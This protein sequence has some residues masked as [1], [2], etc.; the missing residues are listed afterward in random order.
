MSTT[1][2][3]LPPEMGERAVRTS[4]RPLH[5]IVANFRPKQLELRAEDPQ[6]A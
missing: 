5:M 6:E 2:N 3:Q 4:N 1:T